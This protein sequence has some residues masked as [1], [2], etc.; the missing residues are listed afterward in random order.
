MLDIPHYA[1]EYLHRTR[2]VLSIP[3][4]RFLLY[5]RGGSPC[6]R[7]LHGWRG[8]AG[9]ERDLS[10]PLLHVL[11]W[12]SVHQ[13]HLLVPVARSSAT[14]L[15]LDPAGK[16]QGQDGQ[17]HRSW[18]Q[19]THSWMQFREY[20]GFTQRMMWNGKQVTQHRFY[21]HFYI[22]LSHLT[23]QAIIL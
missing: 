1:G 16:P 13:V 4:P 18:Q 14:L 15:S 22:V 17:H 6:P 2:S 11:H 8:V 3:I 7:L 23:A 12:Q 9:E 21:T 5:F 19:V 10:A 20:G